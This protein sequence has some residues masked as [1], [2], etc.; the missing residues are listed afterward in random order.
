MQTIATLGPSI[1]L[2]VVQFHMKNGQVPSV[3]PAYSEFHKSTENQINNK[4]GVRVMEPTPDVRLDLFTHNNYQLI[5][6][7]HELDEQNWKYRTVRYVLCNPGYVYSGKLNPDFLARQEKLLDSLKDLVNKNLWQT[8]G[9]LNP[10]FADQKATDQSVLMF[11][12]NSR[13]ATFKSDGQPVTVFVGGHDKLT[14]QG[15]GPM[16]PLTDKA[17][18]LKLVGDEVVLEAPE[19]TPIPV[20]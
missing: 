7:W 12:S 14:R 3:V 13:K 6:A 2:L 15:I 19:S 16:V 1:R 5:D 8:M 4:S 17:H 18:R 10:F 11:D 9:H 20:S